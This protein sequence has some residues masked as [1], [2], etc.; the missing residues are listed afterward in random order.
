MEIVV[1]NRDKNVK[2]LLS[3]LKGLSYI[4]LKKKK[5]YDPKFVKMV[6]DS[7]KNDK[8]HT[9]ETESIWESI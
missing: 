8:L 5:G 7:A 4:R 6:L 1:D 3:Y 2:Q 9:I